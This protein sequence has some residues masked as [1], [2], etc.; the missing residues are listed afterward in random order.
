MSEDVRQHR[1]VEPVRGRVRGGAFLVV[2]IMLV[3]ANLRPAVTSLGSVLEEVRAAIGAPTAWA[4][5]LTALPPVCFGLAGL[6]VPVITR[7]LGLTWSVGG[8]VAVIV[9][10]VAARVA[11]GAG[12]ML[13]GTFVA[14]AGIAVCNV[15]IP[16]VIKESYPRRIG[17]VTGCYT[18]A[19]QGAAALGSALTPQ[20]YTTV[21]GWRP[22]LGGWASLAV[23]AVLVWAVA[24]PRG[25]VRARPRA[26]AGSRPERRSMLRNRLA[27]QVTGYFASQSLFAYVVM[28][29]LPEVLVDAGVSRGEAGVLSGLVSLLGV[30]VSLVIAPLAARRPSQS[31]WASGLGGLSLAGV[32]GLTLAPSAAP[33]L[34]SV[35]IGVGMGSFAIAVA[36]ISL[37]SATTADTEALST[38]TQSIGY[39]IAATGPL[40]FGVL[41]GLLDGWTVPFVLVLGVLSAQVVLG[42]FAGR[43]RY[44]GS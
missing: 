17:L 35:L 36:F 31:W 30:P 14:C 32:L 25:G 11:D 26:E 28:G 23:L 5:L 13:L 21:G 27:W 44:V 2:A 8:S 9:I 22:A 43:D 6:G 33:L 41:H 19:L 24:A 18:A 20:L 42:V 15:L 37:R 39:L 7:R 40:A 34:W 1:A 29:W 38:M 16:V 10:G 3:A 12:V 4:S